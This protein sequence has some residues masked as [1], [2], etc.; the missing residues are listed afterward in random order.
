MLESLVPVYYSD[1]WEDCHLHDRHNAIQMGLQQAKKSIDEEVLERLQ[2]CW[3][4][5]AYLMQVNCD[6]SWT[7]NLIVKKHDDTIKLAVRNVSYF[8]CIGPI[9]SSSCSFPCISKEEKALSQI[10]DVWIEKED[11]L[12]IYILLDNERFLHI[13]SCGKVVLVS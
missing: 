4:H 10:L 12:V 6:D 8:E 1:A 9:I 2:E 7:V 5:D 13:K 3:F 11:V